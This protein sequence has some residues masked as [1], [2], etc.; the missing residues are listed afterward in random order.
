[1]IKILAIQ[2][3]GQLTFFRRVVLFRPKALR[4]ILIFCGEDWSTDPFFFERYMLF[5]PKALKKLTKREEERETFSPAELTLY[6]C[7]AFGP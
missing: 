3:I 1:M 7:S 4:D 6:A 2:M 5:R